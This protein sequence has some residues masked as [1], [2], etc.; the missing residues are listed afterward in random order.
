MQSFG[1]ITP[2]IN[3]LDLNGLG[4][5]DVEAQSIGRSLV[6]RSSSDIRG[7]LA[8]LSEDDKKK[9]IIA[10]LAAGGDPR[11]LEAAMTTSLTQTEKSRTLAIAWGVAGTISFAASIYHGY[12]RNDSLGWAL[13]WGF[14]GALLPIV[15][16]TVAIAQGF[17]KPK[18]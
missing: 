10:Y 7:A 5:S 1:L 13:W 11:T 14:M 6:R 2:Q 8:A 12:K 15:T 3:R 4:M 17:A 18:R 9:V 16:P